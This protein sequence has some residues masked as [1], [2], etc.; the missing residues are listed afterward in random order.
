ME[1]TIYY[2]DLCNLSYGK[3][4]FKKIGKLDICVL[5]YQ[6]CASAGIKNFQLRST[7]EKCKGKGKITKKESCGY[8]NDYEYSTEKCDC[9]PK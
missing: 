8:H 2:C 9:G 7:C 4:N 6:I 1:K 3:D 5:C